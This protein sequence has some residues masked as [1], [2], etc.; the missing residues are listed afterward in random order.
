MPLPVLEASEKLSRVVERNPDRFIRF[1]YI[2]ALGSVRES[3]SKLIG[4]QADEC[5]A[6]PNATHGINNVLSNFIWKAGDIIIEGG[7]EFMS[8][9]GSY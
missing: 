9:N 3:L 2:N 4:A 8:K 1:D 6:V 5:V 7:F